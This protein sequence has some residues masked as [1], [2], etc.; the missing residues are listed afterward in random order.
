MVVIARGGDEH[1]QA[2]VGREDDQV[3]RSNHP[4]I[5]SEMGRAGEDLVDQVGAEKDDGAAEG[6]DH[7]LLVGVHVAAL[8][9]AVAHHQEGSAE[10][11]QAG[12]EMWERVDRSQET[13][14]ALARRQRPDGSSSSLALRGRPGASRSPSARTGSRRSLPRPWRSSD[15][16]NRRSKPAPEATRAAQ[17]PASPNLQSSWIVVP[18]SWLLQGPQRLKGGV[19]EDWQHQHRNRAEHGSDQH[20]IDDLDLCEQVHEHGSHQPGLD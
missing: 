14:P 5:L 7:P 13:T 9:A 17:G 19:R 10:C 4:Q 3:D 12:V 2:D 20:R 16:Q 6:G 18:G 8:D 15:R 11:V 1:R